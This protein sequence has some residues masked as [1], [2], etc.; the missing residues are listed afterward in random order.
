MCD[1]T[2]SLVWR[3]SHFCV[4]WLIP[5][6]EARHKR[7]LQSWRITVSVFLSTLQLTA[8][9]LKKIR[10]RLHCCTLSF[11]RRRHDTRTL[12]SWRNSTPCM[13]QPW[14]MRARRQVSESVA[15]HTWMSASY[16]W[17]FF[18]THIRTWHAGHDG[19]MCGGRWISTRLFG[20]IVVVTCRRIDTYVEPVVALF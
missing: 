18:G 3:G 4:A 6:E 17:P 16:T 14:Q 5:Q 19:R 2:H 10:L 12:Q 15:S 11:L 1:V 8:L 7:T 20:Y 13:K 9:L